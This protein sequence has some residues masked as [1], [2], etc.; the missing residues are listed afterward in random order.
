MPA[1]G[2]DVIV[3]SYIDGLESCELSSNI[4][5][6]RNPQNVCALMQRADVAISGGGQTLFEL[7][8][9]GTPTIAFC[10][11]EDQWPTLMALERLGAIDYLGWMG[12]VGWL[13]RL[14]RSLRRMAADRG[15]RER[16]GRTASS[17]VDGSGA[18]RTVKVVE[19]LV[20]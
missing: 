11:G 12:Q 15:Y 19:A 4:E 6:H 14:H 1:C 8:R 7:A 10:L 16:L 2:T 18:L 17:L 13:K 3:G 20:S 5:L 9:C